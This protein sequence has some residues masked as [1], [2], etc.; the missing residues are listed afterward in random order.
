MK[1]TIEREAQKLFA[2]FGAK[3]VTMDNISL[4]SGVSKTTL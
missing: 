3:S 4:Q 1:E 2:Q